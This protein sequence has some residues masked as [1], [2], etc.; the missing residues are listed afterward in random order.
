[1]LTPILV[2]TFQEFS[3]V[4]AIAAA[5]AIPLAANAV[6]SVH[7][8]MILAGREPGRI[9]ATSF[10]MEMPEVPDGA[11]FFDQQAAS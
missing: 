3:S 2:Y 9:R 4:A 1:M 11:S 7:A 5:D 6:P 10:E 8:G